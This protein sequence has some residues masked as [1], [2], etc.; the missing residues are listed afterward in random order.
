MQF[1][2][3]EIKKIHQLEQ[4]MVLLLNFEGWNLKHTGDSS[5]PYDAIGKTQRGYDC[6][7]EMKFRNKYYETKMLEKLKYDRLMKMNKD[8]IKIYLVNDTKGNFMYYLNEIKLPMV[9][10]KRCPKTTI[11][12]NQWEKKEVYMLEENDAIRININK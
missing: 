11:W 5:L 7:I 2:I 10:L 3:M 9:Q 12:N 1:G 8:L 4:A 6:V